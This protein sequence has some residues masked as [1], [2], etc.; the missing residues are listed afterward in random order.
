M[1]RALSIFLCSTA[2]ACASNALG[3]FV[4]L[5]AT[6][7]ATIYQED[8]NGANG[9]GQYLFAGRTN[10]GLT[11]RALLRFD[12]A[13]LPEG[14]LLLSARVNMNVAQGNG[15]VRPM[16]LHRGTAQWTTG[17]SDPA[18]T[19]S[20]GVAAMLGDCTWQWASSNGALG[21]TAWSQSGG[22]F[23]SIASATASTTVL[24][25]Q[26]LTSESLRADVEA[27]LANPTENFGWLLLGDESAIGTA[28]R[29][30]S[31]HAAAGGFVP[32]LELE[33]TIIPAPGAIA[34]FGVAGL[35][36]FTRKRRTTQD[37]S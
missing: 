22:S 27:W 14:A 21:G 6:Q 18:G 11:R 4:T 26:H 37:K 5:A 36:A 30:D 35:L 3:D 28:R 8:A 2:C 24:G 15:G 16:S 31:A 10:Q 17:A 9:S 34:L 33:Y 12:L 23:E 7:S 1:Q 20:V 32:S 19:E 13:A 29:L 25:M